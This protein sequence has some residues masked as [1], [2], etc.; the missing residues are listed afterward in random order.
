MDHIMGWL[1]KLLFVVILAPFFI[2]LFIQLVAGLAVAM[3]PWAIF[4]SAI[5]G[6]LG[7]IGIAI[8]RRRVPPSAQRRQMEYGAP[9][10]GQ[11]R[12]RRPKGGRHG[13]G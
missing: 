13:E 4:Y 8:M 12:I 9:P 11:Y 3:M 6:L 7:G 1:I 10:S 5:T 2:C